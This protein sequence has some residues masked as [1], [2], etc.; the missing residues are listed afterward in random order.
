M[1]CFFS[2]QTVGATSGKTV[3]KE[4]RKYEIYKMCARIRLQREIGGFSIV[5]PL[6]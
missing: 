6:R 1:L 3:Q 5:H 4:A 2:L